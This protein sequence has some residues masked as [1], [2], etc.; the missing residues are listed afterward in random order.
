[1]DI[2]KKAIYGVKWITV[3]TATLALSALLKISI[4]ARYLDTSD[5]GLMALV[6]FVMGFMSLFMDMGLSSAI[7]HV[8]NIKKKEYASLYWLNTFFSI[9][10]FLI[11]YLISP[12]ISNF[13][14]EIEL[15][16]LIRLMG[17]SLILSTLGRQFKTILEK[18]L[19]FKKI[20]IVEMVSAIFSLI[21]AIF[22]AMLDYGIYAL[23]YS[24]LMQYFTSNFIFFIIGIKKK[25]LSFHF[26]YIETKP[27]LRIGVFQVGSQIV[28]YFNRDLD[29]LIVGKFFGSELLGGYSLAKQL[30]FRP[31][32]VLNPI[33][34]KVASPILSRIQ[35]NR[36]KLKSNY[37]M[38]LNIVATINMPIYLGVLVL[39]PWIVS[40]LYGSG[41]ES[42]VILV[43]ILSVYMVF[44]AIGNPAGSLLIAT[45]RTDLGFYWNLI[46][47][48]VLPIA[49]FIG[50]QFS[51]EMVA[52]LITVAMAVLLLPSWYFLIYKL[53]GAK[54]NEFLISLIPN[55]SNI[56][57]NL[58]SSYK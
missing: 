41:Y 50:A 16:E 24:A 58:N 14:S 3:S 42:I 7:L 5:F 49:I 17:I 57:N 30:V 37:L 25:Q 19:M 38:L 28:N 48:T 9:L 15:K 44:R 36:N 4:L 45:G 33:F 32:Q 27:F 20:A 53:I 18:E 6:M 8:Q 26:N 31:A 13:Y 47:L 52:T 51:I 10:L 22:L 34:T 23:V 11:I 2:K 46:T 54:L 40:V 29:I 56:K 1:M 21:L 35:K 12:L 39:A 55:F 43:R